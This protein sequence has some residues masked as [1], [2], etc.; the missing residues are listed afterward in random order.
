M[1]QKKILP[2]ISRKELESQTDNWDYIYLILDLFYK[3]IW[4]KWEEYFWDNIN[5]NQAIL[6]IYD[7]LSWQVNN[8]WFIQLIYNWYWLLIFYSPFIEFIEKIWMKKTVK[9]LREVKVLYEKYEE[10]IENTDRN[11]LNDFSK[12][13]SEMPEFDNFDTK[14]YEIEGKDF[15]ILAKYVK[16]N[17]NDFVTLVD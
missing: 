16:E 12:L 9:L 10:K 8:W 5:D 7:Y 11:D 2:E 1:E 15:E 13:Y 3:E 4:E 17:I 6:T 14:F